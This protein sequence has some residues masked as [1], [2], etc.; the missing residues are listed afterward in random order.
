MSTSADRLN[1]I[2]LIS[3]GKDSF[4]S[5]L[6]CLHHGHRVVALANLFPCPAGSSRAS[7]SAPD[8]TSQQHDQPHDPPTDLNSFMYQ[9]VGHEVVPLYAAATGLP[10]YRQPIAGRA[11]CLERDYEAQGDGA[12]GD[13]AQ[14]D[15]TESMLPL[16]RAVVSRHPEANAL[17]SG[18]ILST[19]QRTRVE[20]VALRLGLAPLSYLWKYP[21][22]P[23]PPG[24]PADE[25]QLLRD[26]A[27]AGLEARIVKV[28]SAGL[29]ERHLWERVT[30]EAGARRV[31]ASLRRFG[32]ADG[33]SLGEGGEFETLVLDGPRALFTKRI[34][35]PERGRTAVPEGGGSAWLMLTGARVEDK[36]PDGGRDAPPPPPPSVRQPALLDA[37]FQTV[38]DSLEP[39]AASVAAHGR[40]HRSAL[41]ANKPP[42][43]AAPDAADSL[44][45]A[46]AADPPPPAGTS[47]QDETADVVDKVRALLSSN[48][49][50]P[51][52]ITSVVVILRDMSDFPHVN[53]IYG[54][55]FAKP[56]PP[57]R[58]TVS[59]GD[60]LPAGRSVVVCVS[61]PRAAAAAA[62]RGGLHVQS[63]SYWAPANIGPYSQAV[64]TAA[65][66]AAGGEPTR[67][68]AV[69]VAGQIPL[70]PASMAL[71]SPSGAAGS[72]RRQA[73]LS[74]QHLWRVGSEMKVQCWASAVAYLARQ[75]S[76]DAAREAAKL[77]GRAWVLAHASPTTLDSETSQTDPWDLKYN[78]QYR[79]LAATGADSHPSRLPDWS[80]YTPRQ[81]GEPS[82][83]V[84]PVFSAEVESL[85]RGSLVEW[86]AH[87]GLKDIAEGSV[88]LARY[89]CSREGGRW[90]SWHLVIGTGDAVAVYTTMAY[91]PNNQREAVGLHQLEREL[92]GA[93]EEC[94]RKLHPDATIAG[95][96]PYLGYVDVTRTGGVG[97]PGGCGCGWKGFAATD[98]AVIPC[99]SLWTLEGERA[100]LAALY[101]TVFTTTDEAWRGVARRGEA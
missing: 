71:E 16:L 34:S 23:P 64:E 5:L 59:C 37:L 61:V 100:C 74:L 68:R 39:G 75:Q 27:A 35:I 24:R 22:L 81:R 94:L 96:K 26:M 97:S 87:A 42:L 72:L 3:G 13:E 82:S 55:L 45:W 69:F 88:E 90:R 1:V 6:H 50:Q 53:R 58:V 51:G 40:D 41:M 77:A 17:C 60:L 101:K 12:Q 62:S 92:G 65:A 49:L 31:Q 46:V 76:E 8:A 21:V 83:C 30:S 36:P 86:H 2:A 44:H 28:A 38:L 78:P 10:L 89:C 52:H 95:P 66:A 4:Y 80:V 91:L 25:A 70:V 9:T 15:E 20:S 84:P 29:D 79:S 63:R 85:P 47:V 32:A 99:R 98:V 43:R 93:Y 73:V 11:V 54:G 14:G 7:A 18:A 33:A 56:N 48:G 57:A 67:L 19:Y